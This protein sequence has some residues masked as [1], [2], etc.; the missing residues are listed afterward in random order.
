MSETK[1]QMPQDS[2]L[3]RVSGT[4]TISQNASNDERIV[5]RHGGGIADTARRGGEERESWTV[6][7][8]RSLCQITFSFFHAYATKTGLAVVFW[9]VT[10]C[11]ILDT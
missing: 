7:S 6:G 9:E 10:S 3:F 4:V 5:Q 1:L 2:S 8:P 11:N